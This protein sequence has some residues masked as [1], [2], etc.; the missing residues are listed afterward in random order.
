LRIGERLDLT[1]TRRFLR[2]ADLIRSRAVDQVVIDLGK[3]RQVFDSG[4]AVLLMLCQQAGEG[5]QGI[6][7]VNCRP[8]LLQRLE[9]AGIRSRLHIGFPTTPAQGEE[10]E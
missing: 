1:A 2:A 5:V 7:L 10:A 8:A 3:T 4:L 9:Q 6:V